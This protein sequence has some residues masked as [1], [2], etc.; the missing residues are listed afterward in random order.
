[1]GLLGD[2]T[3]SLRLFESPDDQ[4]FEGHSPKNPYNFRHFDVDYVAL[5]LDGAQIPRKPLQP[6]FE[7]RSY[8]RSYCSLFSGMNIMDRN[9]GHGISLSK[10]PKGFS[11]F[12][13]GLSPDLSEDHFQLISSGN[14]RLE[15]YLKNPLPATINVVIYA[16]FSNVIECDKARNI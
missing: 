5:F 1:M 11:L 2:E 16:E 10:Y 13:F 3:I 14:L 7:N 12:A 9:Q 15:L 4:S 8:N 6:H